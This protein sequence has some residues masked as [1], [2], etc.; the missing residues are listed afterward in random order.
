MP[1]KEPIGIVDSVGASAAEPAS[2]Y[3]SNPPATSSTWLRATG[4]KSRSNV[5]AAMCA[6]AGPGRVE[7]TGISTWADPNTSS[8]GTI[9]S[10]KSCPN[11]QDLADREQRG[12]RLH[13]D[14]CMSSRSDPGR[15]YDA[16]GA[17]CRRARKQYPAGARA[18]ELAPRSCPHAARPETQRC[19]PPYSAAALPPPCRYACQARAIWR[20]PQILP[21]RPARSSSDAVRRP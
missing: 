17:R 20:R 18:A 14:F 6:A 5:M 2:R 1:A 11:P 19:S 13:R 10:G 4:T 9:P 12:R 3:I 16:L 7:A 21:G 8:S 15:C